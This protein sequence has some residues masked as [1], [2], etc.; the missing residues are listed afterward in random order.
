MSKQEKIFV[1]LNN[2]ARITP[3]IALKRWG[4][5]RL[6]SVIHRLREAGNIILTEMKYTKDG[7]QYAVY[8]ME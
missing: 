6:A 2:G 1:A 4:I 5:F 8:S 3:Q 7:D